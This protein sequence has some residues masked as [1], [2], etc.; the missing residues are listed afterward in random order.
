M[1]PKKTLA[2]APVPSTAQP[3]TLIIFG[4]EGCGYY[5]AALSKVQ[6]FTRHNKYLNILPYCVP[7]SEWSKIIHT[8]A[9]NQGIAHTTSPL[10]FC[11]KKYVG[12]HDSLVA[13]IAK[14]NPF[15]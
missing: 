7:K 12:G 11:D 4:Y 1:P 6:E 5:S 13:E 9:K 15:A 8:Y 2:S 10:I 14:R 3:K